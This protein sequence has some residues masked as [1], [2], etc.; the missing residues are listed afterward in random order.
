[1]EIWVIEIAHNV[2]TIRLEQTILLITT[3]T[4]CNQHNLKLKLQTTAQNNRVI[5]LKQI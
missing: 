1:M 2:I 4:L 5:S 3:H